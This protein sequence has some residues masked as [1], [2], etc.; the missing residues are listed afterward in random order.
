MLEKNCSCKLTKDL[1]HTD[2]VMDGV[3]N[4]RVGYDAVVGAYEGDGRIMSVI[5]P[6][7][8]RCIGERTFSCCRRLEGVDIPGSV[9][10]I[11]DYAFSSCPKL[12]EIDLPLGVKRIGKCAFAHCSG[13]ERI[14]LPPSIE[15][16]GDDAFCGC[17]SESIFEVEAGSYACRYLQNLDMPRVSLRTW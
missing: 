3:V 12:K 8:M 6:E 13:L 5:L 9:I 7:G 16:I 17:S 10:A 1:V 15:E 14:S 4:I 2:P 11:G